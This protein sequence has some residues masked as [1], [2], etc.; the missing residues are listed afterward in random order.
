MN[1]LGYGSRKAEKGWVQSRVG[2]LRC[3][4]QTK[5]TKQ[6][7]PLCCE[8]RPYTPPS[9]VMSPRFSITLLRTGN[10]AAHPVH[11]L[12]LLDPSPDMVHGSALRKT[13]SST[14]DYEL[15]SET[16]DSQEGTP[17]LL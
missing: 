16:I 15:N 9:G 14:Q 2:R 4:K 6:K 13:R 10:L 1:I 7:Q 5:K 8:R 11:R 3:P 17:P 12:M